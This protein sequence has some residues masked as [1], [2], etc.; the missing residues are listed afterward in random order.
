MRKENSGRKGGSGSKLPAHLKVRIVFLFLRLLR[1]F[2]AVQ[3]E[4]SK[5]TC[6]PDEKDAAIGSMG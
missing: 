3:I 4:P 6:D 2:A 1:L 5:H